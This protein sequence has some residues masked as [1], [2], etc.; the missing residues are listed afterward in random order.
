MIEQWAREA[1][2]L[3][4]ACMEAAHM[5]VLQANGYCENSESNRIAEMLEKY[6]INPDTG[7]M[8]TKSNDGS[9]NG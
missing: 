7:D 2:L 1:I 9:P 8:A 5:L 6:E 3:H 4:N